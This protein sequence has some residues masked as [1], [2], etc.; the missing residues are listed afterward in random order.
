MLDKKHLAVKGGFK[1]ILTLPDGTVRLT[2]TL[3]LSLTRRH[4][5]TF[6]LLRRLGPHRTP[7]SLPVTSER[8]PEPQTPNPYCC[9]TAA[10][11]R[12]LPHPYRSTPVRPDP[13]P[14]PKLRTSAPTPALYPSPSLPLPLSLPL[15]LTL[16][17]PLPGVG[18][19]QALGWH[20]ASQQER[21]GATPAPTPNLPLPLP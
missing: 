6:E 8:N 13:D 3:T 2:L 15:T 19:E 16:T 11:P 5:P 21:P 12:Q 9:P 4:G 18:L 10:T 20:N 1:Q 7:L 17:L 14:N